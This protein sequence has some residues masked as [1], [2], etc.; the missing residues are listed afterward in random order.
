M[1]HRPVQA[2][3]RELARTLVAEL[4]SQARPAG[5]FDP[6]RYFRTT[7]PMAFYNVRTPVVRAL[8]RRVAREHRADWTMDEAIACADVLLLDPHLE[9]KGLGVEIV[10]GFRR[11]STPRNLP[12]WKRWLATGL[13]A[14]WATTDT[15]C[16]SLI[17]P[18]L[19]ARPE[20]VAT[21]ASW[22]GHR[23]LWVRRASAVALVRLAARG[24]SL[25][26]AYAVAEALE[27]DPHDLIHKAA[28]WLLREAGRTDRARL[29]AYVL[30]RG[31]RMPRTTLRYAVEHLPQ[32]A[33]R[34]ILAATRRA[35]PSRAPAAARAKA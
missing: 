26:T 30:A 24:L 20:L 22:S 7:V 18:L 15:I 21:V 28:G 19:L 35:T 1:E 4:A 5:A 12:H 29:E 6:A 14:N 16:G 31:P 8:G 17:G 33:R 34:R 32:A 23:N 13:A 27:P 2:E 9:A 3:M 11:H 10:A 25:D